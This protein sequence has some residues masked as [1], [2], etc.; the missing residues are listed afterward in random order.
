MKRLG[1]LLSAATLVLSPALAQQGTGVAEWIENLHLTASGTVASVNNISRTSYEPTRKDATTYEL[2]LSSTH[3]RQLAPNLLLV[4]TGEAVSLTVSDYDLADHLRF[5]GRLSLQR[6]FG[7]GPQAA[8]LQFNTAAT[9]QAARLDADSGWTTEAGLQLA[10]RVL[11]NLRLAA[12]ATWLEHNARSAVFDLNQ[13]SYAF[14]AQWDINDRWTLAGS[15]GRLSGDIVANAAWPIW[16]TMLAGG[17]G[18]VIFD[19]YTSRP[20]TT[21]HQFG[22]GWVSYNVEADVDLWSVALSY[23]VSDRTSLELRKSA[24]YVVNA[25]GIAYPTDTW[26]LS[27][28][29]RF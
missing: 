15:A 25:V 19:Y 12:R 14:D 21:T 1:L 23:A 20:W 29:H 2:N 24:A 27:L 4:A 22:P 5:A 11:P 7:L 3:A 9:Y 10:K 17:F 28:T 13:R 18:P 6:K 8:V 16:G 26:G